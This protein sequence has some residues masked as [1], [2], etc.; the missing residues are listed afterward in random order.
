MK[1]PSAP[2]VRHFQ[3]FKNNFRNTLATTRKAL[4]VIFGVFR[5]QLKHIEVWTNLIFITHT[6]VRSTYPA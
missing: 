2:L 5:S 1:T 6:A 3:D 4:S